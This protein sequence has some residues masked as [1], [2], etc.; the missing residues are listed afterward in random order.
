MAPALRSTGGP[1]R[2]RA[3]GYTLSDTTNGFDTDRSLTAGA[4]TGVASVRIEDQGDDPAGQ[5]GASFRSPRTLLAGAYT[6]LVI[7]DYGEEAGALS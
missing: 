2:L 1:V 4:V 3:G 6:G 5:A 7:A